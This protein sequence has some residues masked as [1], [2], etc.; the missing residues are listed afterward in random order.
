VNHRCD[1]LRL[2]K[3]RPAARRGVVLLVI[4]VLLSVSLVLFGV[5]AR[6]AVNEQDRLE[7]QQKRLQTILLAEAGLQRAL[8]LRAADPK[9][10]QE[11]WSVPAAQLDQKHAAEVRI[12]VAPGASQGTLRYEAVALFPVGAIR[13]VQLTKSIEIPNPV[14]TD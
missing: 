7:T 10:E 3:R 11:T 13:H 9:F 8:A 4:I 6:Q 2:R 14:P 12:S 5:W 1:Y